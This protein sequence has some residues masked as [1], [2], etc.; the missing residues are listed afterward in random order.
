MEV[1]RIIEDEE[2]NR[3]IIRATW[4]KKT[5]IMRDVVG[6][7]LDLLRETLA[8]MTLDS[9][10]RRDMLGGMRDIQALSK[11]IADLNLLLRLEEGKSTQN[12]A[13]NRSFQDTRHALQNLAKV[14]P[15]FSY[16]VK[17]EDIT[18]E[19]ETE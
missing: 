17:A 3:D 13:V 14:D 9:G 11:V 15:V 4:E 2:I 10:L 18:E 19:S 6:M 5:P 7:G 12:V 8:E 1:S 16:P